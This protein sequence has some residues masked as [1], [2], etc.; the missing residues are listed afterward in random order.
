MAILFD[1]VVFGPV[2]SRRFGVSLGVNL[3]P[4]DYKYCSFN[5]LYCECGW[6]EKKSA[7]KAVLPS[8]DD[9]QN[10][11]VQKLSALASSGIRPDHI[12]FAGNGEPTLHPDFARIIDVTIQVR[13]RLTPDAKVTVLSNATQ[14][15]KKAVFGALNNVDDNVLKLDSAV[16]A[17]FRL[18]NQPAPGITLSKILDMIRRFE[19][20]QV[21]QTLFLR[22]HWNGKPVDNTTSG[23][24]EAW[25]EA[26]LSINPKYV[27]IY[28]ID[29]EAPVRTLVKVPVE[30]LEAI[31]RKVEA[32]GIEARVFG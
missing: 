28:S 9:V 3:L 10:A 4:V 29:R 22:G 13:N 14:L 17:T 5:C 20:N 7:G 25:L 11:L 31:A 2:K 16:E 26:L 27:M 19:G 21:I 8:V 23:E 30:E 6:N 1:E 24:V 15:H 32:A 18:I 12:T